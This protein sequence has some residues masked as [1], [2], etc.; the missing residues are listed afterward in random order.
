MNAWAGV[1]FVAVAIICLIMALMGQGKQ[2]EKYN[3]MR[4]KGV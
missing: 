4:N 2:K 3:R 1:F